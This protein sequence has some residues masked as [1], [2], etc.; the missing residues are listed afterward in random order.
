MKIIIISQ[1]GIA[2]HLTIRNITLIDDARYLEF[3]FL[4]DN[5]DTCRTVPAATDE[6]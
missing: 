6:Q 5:I 4:F 1:Y 2:Q 3:A